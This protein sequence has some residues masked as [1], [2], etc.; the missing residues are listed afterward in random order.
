MLFI[1]WGFIARAV[2][3]R[4][5]ITST[6]TALA[7]TLLIETT[8]L[9]GFWGYYPCA[10]RIFDVDDIFTNTL[11]GFIGAVVAALWIAGRRRPENPLM[12]T[13]RD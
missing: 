5:L 6:L 9:T 7:A 13:R 2:F 1:P 3:K 12:L 4:R 11:G 10:Y 8:Q